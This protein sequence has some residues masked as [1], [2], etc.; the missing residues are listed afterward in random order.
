MHWEPLNLHRRGVGSSAI[1]PILCNQ[2]QGVG[3]AKLAAL[4]VW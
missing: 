4:L 3:Q 2:E 1:I